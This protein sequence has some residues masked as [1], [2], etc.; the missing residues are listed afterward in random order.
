MMTAFPSIAAGIAG[1]CLGWGGAALWIDPKPPMTLPTG[2]PSTPAKRTVRAHSAA[3]AILTDTTACRDLLKASSTPDDR[4]PLLRRLDRE[5]ALRRW[6]ELDPTGALTEAGRNPSSAFARDLFRAWIEL[7]PAAALDALNGANRTL[8]GAV[9]KEF[10]VALMAKD[11]AMAAEELK[12]SK[13]KNED[14]SF[15]GWNFHSEVHAQWMRSDP[16]AAI[17]SLA[18]PNPEMELEV[19][20]Y[21]MAGAWAEIDFKAAWKHFFPEGGGDP[22]K[23]DPFA[24][25]DAKA[26]LA[27]GLLAGSADA[28]KILESL[29]EK[30]ERL[31][32]IVLDHRADIAESMVD[33]NPAAAL[34]WANSRPSDDP[35]RLRILASAASAIASSD[36]EQALSLLGESGGSENEWENAGILRESFAALAADDPVGTAARIPQLP[37]DQRKDAISGYLTRVFAT[38]PAAATEQC[39]T[40]L[41]DP[42]LRE[43]LPAGWAKA[44][45][46][47]HGAGA[48]DPGEFLT[49]IP[50]LNDAVDEDVLSSWAKTNPQA[51]AGWITGR[52]DQGKNIPFGNEGILAEFAISIPE[53]TASWLET[54]PDPAIQKTAAATLAANWG[55]FDPAAARRWIDTLPEGELRQAAEA[56]MKRTMDRR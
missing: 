3:I 2:A 35:L 6:I 10:F 51:A 7:D 47:G 50:E 37:D 20:E 55:A 18:N 14:A 40:W 52:I 13:W 33:E 54:L 44:F 46:W 4:H 15:L 49:A 9:A 30:P 24:S 41:T 27:V 8:V 56:G 42:A 43:H 34:E 5:R 25:Q 29:P 21:A 53:F 45:S 28:L 31:G 12:S 23:D 19:V 36:P 1:L 32:S 16:A 22:F 11:P 39:R 48:R 17:A 38:N 26:M